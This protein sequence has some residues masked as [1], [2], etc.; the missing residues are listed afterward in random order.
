MDNVEEILA[1]TRKIFLRAD[2]KLKKI[3]K[4]IPYVYRMASNA[5]IDFQRKNRESIVSLDEVDHDSMC[6]DHADAMKELSRKEELKRIGKILD[7]LPREQAEVVK[8][9]VFDVLSF[10]E[11]AEIVQCSLP[12]VK[13]RF[14][15]G[16]SK[17]RQITVELKEVSK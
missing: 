4:I 14:R 12:T 7:K 17:L 13:S 6:V 3:K 2:R 1:E 9:R 16:L 10:K 15:Y 11:I 8:F 5:C